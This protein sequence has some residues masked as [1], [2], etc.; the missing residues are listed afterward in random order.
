[1]A[2]AS[3]TP[4]YVCKRLMVSSVQSRHLITS[5]MTP[6]LSSLGFSAVDRDV[7]FA[8]L[9][10]FFLCLI[11]LSNASAALFLHYRSLIHGRLQQ[12]G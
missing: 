2:A 11:F 4:S 8:D 6:I 1:M 3:F 10:K 5:P 7:F 9:I 12:P